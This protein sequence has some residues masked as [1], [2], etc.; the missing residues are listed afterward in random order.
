MRERIRLSGRKQITRSTFSLT[1]REKNGIPV[2]FTLSLS[3]E[4]FANFSPDSEV[5]IRF[6]EGKQTETVSFGALDEIRKGVVTKEFENTKYFA[7]PFCQLRIS[8][9]SGASAGK[10]LGSTD[11]WKLRAS[12]G[13]KRDSGMTGILPFASGDTDPLP[14]YVEFPGDSSG[15]ILR[16]DNKI[17]HPSV[18][19][20]KDPV[21]CTCVLPAVVQIVL[22]KILA[23]GEEGWREQEW[24]QNWLFWAENIHAGVF[25]QGNQDVPVIF[26]DSFDQDGWTRDLAGEFCRNHKFLERLVSDI[27]KE[28]DSRS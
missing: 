3:D 17:P 27:G 13:G 9:V 4:F 11:R 28:E 15:P 26:E 7:D 8:D 1:F 5:R 16:L 14:W 25:A 10:I 2:K 22:R 24:I 23:L 12:E 19:V 20:T 18:W 21:F 6:T